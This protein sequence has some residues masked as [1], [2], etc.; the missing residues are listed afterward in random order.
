MAQFYLAAIFTERRLFK[1]SLQKDSGKITLVKL[2]IV[3]NYFV[4]NETALVV[5][6][7]GT[8]TGSSRIG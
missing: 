6:G 2:Y 5:S 1:R 7:T 8:G 3:S 4:L